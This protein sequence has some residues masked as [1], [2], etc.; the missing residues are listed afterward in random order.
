MLRRQVRV[1]GGLLGQVLGEWRQTEKSVS[2][3][4]TTEAAVKYLVGS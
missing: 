1:V 4:Q 3:E 2:V